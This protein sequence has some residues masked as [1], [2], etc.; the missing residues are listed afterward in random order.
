MYKRDFAQ[1]DTEAISGVGLKL[2]VVVSLFNRPIT[3]HLLKG[4]IEALT[5]HGVNVLDIEVVS[6]PGAFEIPGM[7]KRM[8]RSGQFNALICLGAVIQGETP[9]FHYIS[10]AVSSGIALLTL[11][12]DIP[13]I[14]GL[15]TTS[16]WE[17]A[18]ARSGVGNAQNKG[19]AS[20]LAALKM[21]Q[22]YR[23]FPTG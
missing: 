8:G 15:L 13:V 7:A 12:L 20:A 22:L 10:S 17:Q 21:V 11:E 23:H 6:V 2:G 5:A 19:K 14:F 3:D 4:T 1:N 9:H 18:E 16:T